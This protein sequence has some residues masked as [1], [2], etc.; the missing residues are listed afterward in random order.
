ML[1]D[2][3]AGASEA[4][5]GSALTPA[6]L[7]P[8]PAADRAAAPPP[9]A[10]LPLPP[11]PLPR[12]TG[13]LFIA[14]PPTL[15]IFA[16]AGPFAAGPAAAGV[17]AEFATTAAETGADGACVEV[18]CTHEAEGQ[19]VQEAKSKCVLLLAERNRM[20]II[21]NMEERHPSNSALTVNIARPSTPQHPCFCSRRRSLP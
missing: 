8:E 20:T 9:R 4:P 14:C 5:L 21:L 2:S 16:D 18:I 15:P 13:R 12:S 6:E 1:A 11:L 17:A 19:C 7:P 10:A 3:A